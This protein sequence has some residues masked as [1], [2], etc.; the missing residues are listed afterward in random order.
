MAKKGTTGDR[1]ME[2][3]RKSGMDRRGPQNPNR[4]RQPRRMGSGPMMDGPAK[5]ALRSIKG[6]DLGTG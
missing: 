5:R 1:A 2:F 6:R 3:T 4:Q